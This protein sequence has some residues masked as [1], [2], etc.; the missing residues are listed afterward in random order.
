MIA[1][2]LGWVGTAGTFGA[3]VLLVQGRWHATSIRYAALNGVAGLLGATASSIYGAWPSAVSNLLWSGVA[4][5]SIVSTYRVRRG[6]LP[7]GLGEP[8]ADREPRTGDL[9]VL[10]AAA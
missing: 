4:A 1:A 9:V 8:D 3:Y 7:V 5:H 2:A 6:A 10:A